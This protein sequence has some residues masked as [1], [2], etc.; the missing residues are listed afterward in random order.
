MAGAVRAEVVSKI[1]VETT[2]TD[3][4]VRVRQTIDA[5]SQTVVTSNSTTTSETS[6]NRVETR[7]NRDGEV[8]VREGSELKE[9]V[10]SRVADMKGKSGLRVV[11][12]KAIINGTGDGHITVTDNDRNIKVMIGE[13]T[14]I[15]RRFFGDSDIGELAIGHEVMVFGWWTDDS[16]TVVEARLIRDLSIQVRFGVF[17]G[18]VES[19]SGTTATITTVHRGKQTVDL[20]GSPIFVNRKMETIALSDV[21]AGHRIRVKGL[22]DRSANTISEVRQVKDYSLP[23]ISKPINTPEASPTA[24]TI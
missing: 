18:I 3:T 22:W 15:V 14:K 7:I 20:S 8:T 12:M 6:K 10:A 19:I 4:S 1:T 17:I 16:K 2:G 13:D 24:E 11:F 23:E 5:S 9:R 21:K